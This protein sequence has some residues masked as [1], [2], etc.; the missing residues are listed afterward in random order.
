M[1]QQINLK[2][3]IKN[4]LRR[5]SKLQEHQALFGLQ[6]PPA[7][8]IEIEDIIWSRLV[9]LPNKNKPGMMAGLN[10]KES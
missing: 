3:L 8:L 7:L 2:K 10:F 4:H 1:A 5:L 6:A 9:F